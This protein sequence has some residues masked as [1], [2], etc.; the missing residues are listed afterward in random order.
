MT[1]VERVR[2]AAAEF[3]AR[4][5]PTDGGR[6]LWWCEVDRPALVLGSTQSEAIVNLEACE[7]HG[8]EVVRRRSGGGAVLLWPTEV[9]WLD[10]VIGGGDPRWDDDVG[11][12]MWWVGD[13]WADALGAV[14]VGGLGGL[15]P[16]VHHGALVTTPWSRQVCFAGLG[17]GEVTLGERKLV[18]ISQRRSRG[19][20]RFQCALYRRWRPEL[21]IEL[22][23]PP[24]PA[25]HDLDVVAVVEVAWDT[26]I[27]AVTERF[28][29]RW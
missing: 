9:L 29:H 23:A 15:G 1:S 3:H 27:D 20:A 5:L 16:Q 4:D 17:P 18:G 25:V 19:V 24:T 28:R 22:L 6:H 12:A 26:V 14:G 11:R 13:A 7:R 8:V 21:M 2:G 10:V